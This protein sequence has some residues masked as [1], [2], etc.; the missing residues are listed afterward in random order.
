MKREIIITLITILIIIIA[1]IVT[2]IYTKKCVSETNSM[3]N[4]LKQTI[5]AKRESIEDLIIHS[6]EIY[7][8]WKKR[9]NG[10]AY[11]IEHDEIEKID[12]QMQ[13]ITADLE[14]KA[15]NDT[16]SEI[17]QAIYLLHH[18]EEKRALKLKNV[19]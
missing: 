5:L 9:T 12:V 8:E 17:E 10:L 6:E 13:I 18:I 2:Q 7:N 4:E 11:Y 1:D 3:L 16:I 19:F 14:A 15:D